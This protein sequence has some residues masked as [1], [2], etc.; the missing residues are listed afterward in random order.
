MQ[1]ATNPQTG[2][3]VVLISGEWVPYSQSATNK[4]GVKAF[5]VGDEWI[6]GQPEEESLSWKDVPAKALRNL[7]QSLGNIAKGIYDTVTSPVEAVKNLSDIAA[8]GLQNALPSE[9]VDWINEKFPSQSAEEARNKATAV[10]QFYKSRYGSEE[11]LKKALAEDPAGV[12][13][14][15]ATVLTAGGAVT[16]KA[17][18][19]ANIAKLEKAGSL[20]TKAGIAIDPMRNAATLGGKAVNAA[21]RGAA[22]VIGGLGT[23]TGGKTIQ[24]AFRAGAAGGDTAADFAANMR[25]NAQ[26]ADVLDD[27]KSA[28][29]N[30]YKKR[31]AEYQAGMQGVKADKTVLDFNPI[32]DAMNNVSQIGTYKGK[33]LRRSAAEVQKQISGLIDEWRTADPKEFHTPEGLDALKQAIGDVRDNTAPRSASRVIADQMYNAVKDQITAQAPVYAKTMGQYSEAT[34][35]VKEIERALSLGEKTAADTAMRKLQSLTRNNVQTNYGNRI[36]LAKELEEAGATNLLSNLSGQ[37]LGSWTPRGLG[38]VVAGGAGA[39][40]LLTANPLTIPILASQSPR[41]MGELSYGLGR[42]RGMFGA[43]LGKMSEMAERLGINPAVLA[44]YL[45]QADQPKE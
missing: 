38:G 9:L 17:G 40:G 42:A 11:G 5:L 8:G 31:S 15:A 16:A 43:P 33:V 21:G 4:A 1:T 35:L 18:Q 3:K 26:M 24:D 36:S 32:D 13:A 7:P 22:N 29:S 23:H 39:A 44:N 14:D 41:L 45:Y 10:G 19:L 6:V 12:L 20:A 27:A 28:L 37:A 2:E 34:R 30:L 25:G